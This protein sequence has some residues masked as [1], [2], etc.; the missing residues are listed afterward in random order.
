MN[1]IDIVYSGSVPFGWTFANALVFKKVRAALGLTRCRICISAAAPI[2]RETLEFFLS[3]NVNVT[4][5]YGMS[6][7]TG[8][9]TSLYR[10]LYL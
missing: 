9:H 10:I 6:E 3:L 7:T 4:E 1:V 8:K 5:I 2:M